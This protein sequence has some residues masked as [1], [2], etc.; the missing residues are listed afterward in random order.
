MVGVPWYLSSHLP[1]ALLI[2]HEVGHH[3]E[4]DCGLGSEL[5]D[6][7]ASVGLTEPRHAQWSKWLEE[8]IADVVA[9]LSCGGAYLAVML[10]AL[11]AAPAGGAGEDRYPSPRVRGEICRAT[12][13]FTGPP[14]ANEVAIDGA[15]LGE[16]SI[17]DA[18]APAVVEAILTG[19]YEKLGG[20]TL[21]EVLRSPT[22][23][24]DA[25]AN[26][27]LAG[28]SSKLTD[29]RAVI[30]AAALAFLS[31]PK[32][33]DDRLV[34]Q[35]AIHEVLALRPVGPRGLMVDRESRRKRDA[36]AGQSILRLLSS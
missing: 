13:A 19:P 8:V 17:A 23:D 10:D 4:D 33:Y 32:G 25:G 15:T 35:C 9:S 29:V 22:V 24:A 16:P 30:S 31:D 11:A 28:Y 12:V 3:I 36:A 2:A 27:L 34:G 5:K 1:G 14:V 6:R 7:L 20:K 21:P 18:E 26:R